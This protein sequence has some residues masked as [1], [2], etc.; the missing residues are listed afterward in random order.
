MVTHMQLM[1]YSMQVLLRGS[2]EEDGWQC[3]ISLWFTLSFV[4]KVSNATRCP[5]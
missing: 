4:L 5:K 1:I 2:N 3:G